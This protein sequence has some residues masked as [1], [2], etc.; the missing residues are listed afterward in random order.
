VVV[1]TG[2]RQGC[3][4]GKGKDE[5]EGMMWDDTSSGNMTWCIGVSRI[6]ETCIYCIQ[7]RMHM[8]RPRGRVSHY[9]RIHGSV[10]A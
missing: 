5:D 1:G 4:E 9:S 8:L 10:F 6:W 7:L 3:E 2:K